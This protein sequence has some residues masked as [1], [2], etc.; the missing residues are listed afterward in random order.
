[1]LRKFLSLMLV[2]ML[3]AVPVLAETVSPIDAADQLRA[4]A[5]YAEALELLLPLA[6]EDPSE[7][8]I[9]RIADCYVQ[10]DDTANALIWLERGAELDSEFCLYWLGDLYSDMD[11][12]LY[13]IETA[14]R[15]YEKGVLAGD[16]Y[17]MRDL[18]KLYI[19]DD[20][21]VTDYKKAETLLTMIVALEA[22]DEDS[23]ARIDDGVAARAYELLGNLYSYSAY[24]MMNADKAV[25]CYEKAFPVRVNAA[26]RLGHIYSCD[27]HGMVNLLTALS[28]YEQSAALNDADGL[29]GLADLYSYESYKITNLP[30]AVSYYEQA[31][32]QNNAKALRR[33]G[34]LYSYEGYNMVDVE[35]A[36]SYYEQAAGLDDSEALFRLGGIYTYE[37]FGVV[38]TEKAKTYYEQAANLGHENAAAEL[39]RLQAE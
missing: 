12:D 9:S 3:T 38:D 1:M 14:V 34:D 27:E 5:Q 39:A 13:D 31:A 18:A 21:G 8:V 6:D 2:L 10:T 28:W 33:L 16:E 30:L 23:A 20:Y 17:S 35:K 19:S 22:F 24:G 26:N 7:V 15:W 37:P 36:V 25:A 32:E 11:S 29:I 4:D